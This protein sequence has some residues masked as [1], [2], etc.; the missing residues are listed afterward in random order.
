[1]PGSTSWNISSKS[2]EAYLQELYSEKRMGPRINIFIKKALPIYSEYAKKYNYHH[3]IQVSSLMPEF[4]MNTLVAA[5][6]AYPFIVIQIFDE[7][8]NSKSPYQELF[9]GT[10]A[11][12]VA[13]FR[14]DDDDLLS[15]YYID[16]LSMFVSDSFHGMAVSFGRGYS[17]QFNEDSF[18]DFRS[19]T[20]RFIAIGQAYI[21]EWKGS[22]DINLPKIHAHNKLDDFIPVIVYSKLPLYLWT[23]HS[24]QD[25][26]STNPGSQKL[27]S[28]EL[29][30]MNPTYNYSE[31][32][33]HFPTLEN[34]I[35]ACGNKLSPKYTLEKPLKLKD[36][37]YTIKIEDLE[38]SSESIINVSYKISLSG[39]SYQGRSM[40]F[41]IQLDDNNVEVQGLV[42]STSRNIGF[43]RYMTS[44]TEGAGFSFVIP[45]GKRI[46]SL[47]IIPWESKSAEAELMELVIT[48]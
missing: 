8:G 2:Q 25:T 47:K 10:P 22:G 43:Y 14:V 11:G 32:I 31:I 18:Q 5:K 26:F 46:I 17:A 45:K 1:M 29:L 30:A 13:L 20:K 4:Y 15:K 42:K 9:S 40:L 6:K 27:V 44:V 28:S 19:C 38:I 7:T 16:N 35:L 39:S 24:H 41:A 3:I 36:V 48:T 23:H 34:D 12:S 37:D 33:D 21:F